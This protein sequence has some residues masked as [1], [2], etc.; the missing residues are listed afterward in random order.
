[1]FFQTHK[2][3]TAIPFSVYLLVIK[4]LTFGCYDMEVQSSTFFSEVSCKK[5]F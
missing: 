2:S 4:W 1:M 3:R 5:F